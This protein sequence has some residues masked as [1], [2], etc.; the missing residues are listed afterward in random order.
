M[1][2]TFDLETSPIIDLSE[3]RLQLQIEEALYRT[4]DAG[5]WLIINQGTP[6]PAV[7]M[8]ISGVPEKLVDLSAAADAS[9]PIIRRFTGGGTVIV[10]ENTLFSSLIMDIDWLK[11]RGVPN[12]FPRN[13]MSWSEGFY[14][15]VFG[16]QCPDFALQEHDYAFGARKFGGNA[17]SVSRTRFV[18]HT[19]FLFDYQDTRMSILKHPEKTPTYRDGREHGSFLCKLN[20]RYDSTDV[21]AGHI[22]RAMRD[23]VDSPTTTSGDFA[24]S[25]DI[26]NSL[27]EGLHVADEEGVVIATLQDAVKFLENEHQSAQQKQVQAIGEQLSA[28]HLK[29]MSEQL[30]TFKVNLEEFALKHK[31]DI[32]KN[33]EFRRHFQDMCS[34][35]GVDPL[36]LQSVP[37]EL[38]KDHTD[39]LINAQ[40]RGGVTS[41]SA[42]KKMGW[43]EQRIKNVIDVLLN[44]GIAW[45]DDQGEN[46]ELLYW[47]PSLW[48]N[49]FEN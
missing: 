28:D 8:G 11:A 19:S 30:A 17:Q 24:S 33:P 14:R 48:S 36:A 39:V 26:N 49:T 15:S 7:I 45:I 20:E 22:E 4:K 12:A 40:S 47:F 42:L 18:H 23:L 2:L 31:K 46:K 35:I 3:N 21:V 1:G 29:K 43:D 13:I 37:C 25:D 44:E 10:D 34:T 9:V 6:Q 16:E 41:V 5:N 32:I 38:N 27:L